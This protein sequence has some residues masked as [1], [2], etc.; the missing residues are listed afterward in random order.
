MHLNVIL[1]ILDKREITRKTPHFSNVSMHFGIKHVFLHLYK[2]KKK[3]FLTSAHHQEA[4][5]YMTKNIETKLFPET[6]ARAHDE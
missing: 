1:M 5:Q 3:E 2:L 6:S 4:V